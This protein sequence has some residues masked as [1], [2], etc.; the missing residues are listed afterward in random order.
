MIVAT[1]KPD[2][3][4]YKKIVAKYQYEKGV[5]D[6]DIEDPKEVANVRQVPVSATAGD[7][8]L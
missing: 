2:P 7:P 8:L 1:P 6:A 3:L 5:N 4:G